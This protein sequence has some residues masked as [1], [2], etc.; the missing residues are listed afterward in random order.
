[1]K[2]WRRSSSGCV[3][4]SNLV[5]SRR[6]IRSKLAIRIW[7]AIGIGRAA[8]GSANHV[9]FVFRFLFY[10]TSIEYVYGMEDVLENTSSDL[11][12]DVGVGS[13]RKDRFSGSTAYVVVATIAVVGVTLGGSLAG[14]AINRFG[15]FGAVAIWA[16]GGLLGWLTA[17][18]VQP[19]R[20]FGW[21]LA[22]TVILAFLVAETCWIR[23]NIVGAD[24]WL[25][26]IAKLPT[27]FQTYQLDCL[28]AGLMTVFGAMSAFRQSAYEY[29]YVKV[30]RR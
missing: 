21:L 23:W 20:S 8:L 27:F 30:R 18:F 13:P 2:A 28:A 9:N 19:A 11:G 7:Q 4:R 29:E 16:L 5:S 26:A 25:Q 14:L 17:K 1:M 6:A 10:G 12:G 24:T 15:S 3:I 22:A